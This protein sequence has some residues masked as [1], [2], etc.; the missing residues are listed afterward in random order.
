MDPIIGIDLGTTN[1]AVAYLA[2]DGPRHHPQRPRRPA[3]A[4]RSSAST[5]AGSVLVGAAARELQVVRPDRCAALFKRH[6]G[7]D[8][9][10]TLG[11]RTFT[12]GGTVQPGP[13]VAQGRRR[14]VLR[15]AGHAGR[16]HRARR[17][18][19]T[20]S[21]RRPSPPAGSPGWTVERI[22]NE[23]TAAAIAYGFHDAG[24]DKTL[25]IFDLGGGTFDVSV[26]ELFEGTLEVRA[27]AGES[28]LGGEDFTRDAGRPRPRR[29]G[30]HVRA[31]RGDAA[32]AGVAADPAVRAGQV[33]AVAAR[34]RR[35][36]ACRTRP[37][38]SPTAPE[39]TV[40]REQFEAWVGTDPGPHRAADPPRARRRQA[41][42]RARSTR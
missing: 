9:T 19:T 4:R 7:S 8:W 28:V 2:D 24:E 33:P 38:S 6:M 25:L 13:A 12:P 37:A 39:V 15:R 36:S 20:A 3:H 21:G 32:A 11:G 5:T 26:V 22:L 31:G 17:T 18:S 29:A 40:T 41:D 27:S 14:G 34:R 23:P 10:A 42:P 30:L 16:H 1:S 35:P